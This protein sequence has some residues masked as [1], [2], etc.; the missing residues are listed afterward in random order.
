M[1]KLE[2]KEKVCELCGIIFS[3]TTE[4]DAHQ[5]NLKR[6][7][8]KKCQNKYSSIKKRTIEPPN[9]SGLCLCGCGETTP[10]AKSS[11]NR[12]LTTSKGEHLSFVAGHHVMAI[13]KKTG[14][15]GKYGYGRYINTQGYI[16]RNLN[17]IFKEDHALISS[18][19]IKSRGFIG[20]LEHRYVMAKSLGKPLT[21]QENVHHKNGN[22]TDN[23]LNNLELWRTSQPSGQR[24]SD[25]C[26]HCN[27]SGLK[28]I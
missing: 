21:K 16:F 24:S 20:I 4:R 28:T 7:C 9:P 19:L 18:M 8:S 6:F 12:N 3:Q 5:W 15:K 14:G 23:S 1:K 27:G 2:V 17:S 22:K 11:S 26:E 10:L 13:A 25:I